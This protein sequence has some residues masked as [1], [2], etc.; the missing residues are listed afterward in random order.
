MRGHFQFKS[1][2]IIWIVIC[3][4]K[5]MVAMLDSRKVTGSKEALTSGGIKTFT[6][7]QNILTASKLLAKYW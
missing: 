6:S 5:K 4:L 2:W 7:F 3:G 1:R